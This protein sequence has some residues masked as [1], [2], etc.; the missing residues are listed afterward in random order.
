MRRLKG[1]VALVALVA[2]LIVVAFIMILLLSRPHHSGDSTFQQEFQET[3]RLREGE[4]KKVPASLT[5]PTPGC[6]N[7]F[8]KDSCYKCDSNC[9]KV[10]RAD[11]RKLGCQGIIKECSPGYPDPGDWTDATQTTAGYWSTY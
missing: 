2:L 11:C 9:K 6:S 5:N 4:C 1:L 10:A 3:K 7:N 8:S